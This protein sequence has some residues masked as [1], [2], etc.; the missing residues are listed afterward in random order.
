MYQ[1]TESNRVSFQ[2]PIQ[3]HDLNSSPE[4][5]QAPYVGVGSLNGTKVT[6]QPA[7][8]SM[9]TQISESFSSLF[10]KFTDS[11]T[12]FF[13]GGADR[14]S[15]GF[16]NLRLAADE[17][18]KAL[19]AE[20]EKAGVDLDSDNAQQIMVIFSKADVA[21][22]MAGRAQAALKK[23]PNNGTLKKLNQQAN[24]AAATAKK[25]LIDAKKVLRTGLKE[26]MPAN[27]TFVVREAT[28]A[29]NKA[30]VAA[31]KAEKISLNDPG[32][33]ATGERTQKALEVVRAG[34][35]KEKESVLADLLGKALLAEQA[36]D[37]AMQS[38][39][40][41]EAAGNNLQIAQSNYRKEGGA[42]DDSGNITADQQAMTAAINVQSEKMQ[43][44]IEAKVNARKT[45][46]DITQLASDADNELIIL[47]DLKEQAK[48]KH[49]I[50]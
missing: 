13:A 23:N 19:H 21:A 38:E 47:K 33:P 27:L 20:L 1:V 3:S 48:K 17:S 39:K 5:E 6:E 43:K 26:G 4:A 36:Y 34:I 9:A 22:Q 29:V 35:P 42:I 45:G 28:V 25:A 15:E 40:D 7:P 44:A 49:W 2:A 37:E 24:N 31:E 16:N 12:N 50:P 8:K 10:K 32:I 14:K 30:V 18:I 46:A 11:V 41:V